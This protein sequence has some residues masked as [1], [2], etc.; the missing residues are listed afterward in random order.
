M[1][2]YCQ[3]I[4]CVNCDMLVHVSGEMRW[5]TTKISCLTM[6]SS[7][8]K[9]LDGE[10]LAIPASED[11][12][13]MLR[14]TGVETAGAEE[15]GVSADFAPVE[16]MGWAEEIPAPVETISSINIAESIPPEGEL[17]TVDAPDRS[18]DGSDS[19]LGLEDVGV[20]SSSNVVIEEVIE[21]VKEVKRKSSLKRRLEDDLI[22]HDE[23]P[24]QKRRKTITFD[25][26]TVYY[27]PRVQGFT[28]VPSQGG[29]TLGM[30][31]SH[32]HVQT[33]SLWEHAAE[34]RR[35]HRQA[36]SQLQSRCPTPVPGASSPRSDSSPVPRRQRRK[37]NQQEEESENSAAESETVSEGLDAARPPTPTSLPPPSSSEESADSDE[38]EDED[39][40]ED[41][42]G[43]ED[44]DGSGG[45]DGEVDLD[46]CYFLQVDRLN[47]PCG[48]TRDGCANTNGRIEFN[49]VR[50]RTHF[51]HTLMR[52]ELERKR[53]EAAS[54][55]AQQQHCLPV[56][57]VVNRQPQESF[58]VQSVCWGRS[59]IGDD[60]SIGCSV[61]VESACNQSGTS[62]S[63]MQIYGAATNNHDD[64]FEFGQSWFSGFSS[65]NEE[66][67]ELDSRPPS[68]PF[69][70]SEPNQTSPPNL[71]RSRPDLPEF[72]HILSPLQTPT[73]SSFP[74][75]FSSFDFPD[76]GRP[77]GPVPTPPQQLPM[78]QQG[79]E[80]PEPAPRL[81]TLRPALASANS[82]IL[83]DLLRGHR[84]YPTVSG[85]EATPVAEADALS[86]SP[87][88]AETS[89]SGEESYPEDVPLT[90]DQGSSTSLED[91]G[92]NFGEIIK[93]TMVETV[94]A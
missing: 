14:S 79:S 46:G 19:G 56:R 25:G 9:A 34:Q 78:L 55:A 1:Y 61:E 36:M 18:S 62:F 76:S 42:E 59:I 86:V 47:F 83:S 49:P 20:P 73:T 63:D 69:P 38:D 91:R 77:I 70:N 29:S 31:A 7:H 87:L 39:D 71:N 35:L 94:S 3:T 65:A 40:D 52:L 89:V 21:E 85:A 60:V 32:T 24:P 64:S 41:E 74:G 4:L 23:G 84:A 81:H 28:C 57:G 27:F 80:S 51:I 12:V 54:S 33:F 15:A 93:K 6:G 43:G 22:V 66:D 10:A 75:G 5:I 13:E 68:P 92:E 72:R 37:K 50:V 67:G 30:M 17:P 58:G 53:E 8:P 11:T 2:S 26:V 90:G 88:D 48:C 82:G 45:S 16:E 44:D